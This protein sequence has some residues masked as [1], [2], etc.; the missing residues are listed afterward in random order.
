MKD[1][2]RYEA[3]ANSPIATARRATGEHQYP[4]PLKPPRENALF[5]ELL[6]QLRQHDKQ[7]GPKFDRSLEQSEQEIAAFIET[8]PL[9]KDRPLVSIIMPTFNRGDIIA[10]AIRSVRDQRYT[11][12]ELLICDDGSSDNTFTVVEQFADPRILLMKLDHQG[13]AGARNE[14]MKQAKGEYF[15]YLDSDNLWHPSHLE[16]LVGRLHQHTGHFCIY[17]KYIDVVMDGD[18]YRLKRA[19]SIEFYFERLAEKNYIDLNSFVHRATLYRHFGGFTSTLA[20]QQ[21]W[22]LVLKYAFLRDPLYADVFL[23]LYR[24]NKAWNQLTAIAE[25]QTNST[26]LAV[27]ANLAG[28]YRQGLPTSTLPQNPRKV[29]IVTWDICRNHFSKAYNVAEALARGGAFQ[30]QLIGFRFFEE[31]IFPPYENEEPPFETLYLEGR[32]LPEFEDAYAQ[33]LLAITGD[34]VYC[35]KPRFPSLG[36]GLLANFHFGTPLIMEANDFESHVA[37]PG[38]TIDDRPLTLDLVD[39][40]DVELRNPHS[41]LWSRVMDEFA[42]SLPLITTHNKNLDAHY[43][44]RAFY[45]RNLKDEQHYNPDRYDREAI[46]RELGYTPEDRVILFGGLLRKHK[47][48]YELIELA[49]SLGDPRYKVLFVGSRVSPD[50]ERLARDHQSEVKVLP[51]Q[52][53]NHMAQINYA[54]DLVILWLNPAIPASHYQMPYKFTDAIAMQVPVIANDISDLGDLGRAGYLKVVP[55]GGVELLQEAVQEVFAK[56]EETR[57]MVE[58]A[59]KLYL[60]QFSYQAARSNFEILYDCA[61]RE[62][63]ALPAA[64]S[65]AEFYSR[66]HRTQVTT[67]AGNTR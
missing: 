54:S 34:V 28:Y 44:H 23:A 17:A 56:P 45:I 4:Q 61:L 31:S 52:G 57:R 22:D 18:Q 55:Y 33:A 67:L 16:M 20:R 65:F 21:D 36:L 27:Q 11:N 2:R 43:G 51:P 7:L 24:R 3:P 5:W 13:A 46:R 9:A 47:G 53:R 35:V 14:G 38:K 40:S 29:T 8:K 42:K 15:A 25:A 26:T 6:G 30:V 49:R 58:Y 41:V 66:V 50:Q 48:I 10:Q 60:R 32:T 39:P 37:Q 64:A 62:K 63:R 19:K 1:P 12:W 59:R